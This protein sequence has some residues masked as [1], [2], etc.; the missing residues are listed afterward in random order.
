MPVN[1]TNL[2]IPKPLGTEFFTLQNFNAMLEAIDANVPNWVKSFGLGGA[3]K[4][5]GGLDLN[6]L[7]VTG[8]YSGGGLV[9]GPF[10]GGT[11]WITHIKASSSWKHQTAHLYS[12]TRTF[13]RTCINGT[14]SAW[15][16]VATTEQEAFISLT[17][18]NGWSVYQAGDEG[19]YYKDQFGVVRLKGRF[20][21]GTGTNGTNLAQLPSGYRPWRNYY[22]Q[23]INCKVLISTDGTLKLYDVTS[24]GDICIDVISFR[25][26]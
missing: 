15:K 5:I 12:D 1:T 25:T 21:N 24:T 9:N 3:T 23:C 20:K 2:S 18:Q 26:A 10:A 17:L 19:F 14:W 8:F 16:E 7:D 22:I 6:T 4:D 11:W 13:V